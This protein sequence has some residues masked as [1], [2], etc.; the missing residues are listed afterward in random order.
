MMEVIN[1]YW[2]KRDFRLYDNKA[3]NEALNAD[4]PVL[5]IY[6]IEPSLIADAHYSER[7]WRFVK[8]SIDDLNVELTTYNTSIQVFYGEVIDVFQKIS[9]IYTIT[10]V[11]STQEI[12]IDITYKRDIEFSSYC[13]ENSIIWHEF[14]NGGVVRGLRNRDSWRRL[15]YQYMEEAIVEPVFTHIEFVNAEFTEDIVMGFPT[16]WKFDNSHTMQVGGRTSG[17]L[18]MESFFN[19]RLAFYSDYISKPE[20]A[21]YGCS[22]LSPYIAWGCLS[23]R[24]I[25][26]RCIAEKKSSTSKKQLNAFMSRLRW[27]AHFIQKFEMEPRIEF[28]AFNKG[29]LDLAQPMN[30]EFLEAW[31]TG[32]TGYPLVDASIRAVT[33]T[34]YLN[35]RMRSMCVSFLVHHLFQHFSTGSKWLARQFLDFEPGIHYAQFQMQSGFTATNTIRIYNPTKNALDYDPEAIFIKKFVPELRD[36]PV[37]FAIQPWKMTSM[38]EMLYNFEL[39]KSYPHR[40]VDISETRKEALKK[41]YGKRKDPLT[42]T[43]KERILKM[44]TLKKRFP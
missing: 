1:V 28:E 35:F 17:L 19:E 26:Q 5:L 40:I 43:E 44:H 30:S 18:W 24:E 2:F 25:Y 36:L 3:F 41:L 23:V 34:G 37:D 42:K 32:T 33:Q 14:Q 15:W 31:K 38:E 29:Y 10:K 11:F 21:R 4:A 27:Q 9:K 22:R 12:G 7:H 8:E 16:Y 13:L 6:I 39:G 20:M